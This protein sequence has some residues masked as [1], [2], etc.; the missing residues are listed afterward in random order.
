MQC[1][2]GRIGVASI[3]TFTFFVLIDRRLGQAFDRLLA[4]A[5]S[6]DEEHN[7]TTH[8]WFDFHEETR[9]G[10]LD[11]LSFLLDKV[12]DGYFLKAA[13]GPVTK[14]QHGLVRTNCMDCL[15]RTNVVQS[16]FA[17]R[18]LRSQLKARFLH[19]N[20]TADNAMLY[21][22]GQKE[23]ELD[24]APLAIKDEEVESPMGDFSNPGL[25]KSFRNAWS[26]NGDEVFLSFIYIYI[27]I[28][29]YC[30]LAM[31]WFLQCDDY[32]LTLSSYSI[33]PSNIC[34]DVPSVC[35]DTG[36]E[37]R[38]DPSRKVLLHYYLYVDSCV[39]IK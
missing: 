34:L 35:R 23:G 22:T 27:Y 24:E 30:L 3:L 39:Y 2:E 20:S 38:L 16:L 21:S 33:F 32:L 18:A 13:N 29:M 12:D 28:C 14:L 19:E 4:K 5:V 8:V 31:A 25:E 7:S 1:A 37:R 26:S 15:D 17:K 10:G 36:T 6:D 11:R 9:K